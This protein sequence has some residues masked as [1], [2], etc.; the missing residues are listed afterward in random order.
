[1]LGRNQAQRLFKRKKRGCYKLLIYCVDIK[2]HKTQ[3]VPVIARN[4][5]FICLSFCHIHVI[6]Y[7][8]FFTDLRQNNPGMFKLG[9]PKILRRKPRCYITK[10][11]PFQDKSVIIFFLLTIHTFFLLFFFKLCKSNYLKHVAFLKMGEE[12]KTTFKHVAL[13]KISFKVSECLRSTRFSEGAG[14]EFVDHY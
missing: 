11:L 6:N 13:S 10:I 1:M 3:Q 4:W 12:K 9:I 8:A 7:S 2:W 5:S 14:R